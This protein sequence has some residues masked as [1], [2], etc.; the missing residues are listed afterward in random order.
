MDIHLTEEFLVSEFAGEP[1]G[2]GMILLLS[3]IGTLLLYLAFKRY[4]NQLFA[5]RNRRRAK[6][7]V[8]N[9]ETELSSIPSNEMAGSQ[10]FAA[11]ATAIHLFQNELHD[12][13]NTIM[14]INKIARAYSPWSSKLYIQNQYFQLRRR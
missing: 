10:E 1:T 6:K 13:E 12:E 7:I 2:A 4:R 3:L 11:I 8:E 14:T 5:V 9:I